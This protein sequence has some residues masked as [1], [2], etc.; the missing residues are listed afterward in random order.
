MVSAR[1]RSVKRNRMFGGALESK[2]ATTPLSR[3]AAALTIPDCSFRSA[4]PRF[5]QECGLVADGRQDSQCGAAFVSSFP[6][7]LIYVAVRRPLSPPPPHDFTSSAGRQALVMSHPSAAAA[8]A[9]PGVT[10]ALIGTALALPRLQDL[11][12]DPWVGSASD[13]LRSRWGRRRPIITIGAILA[14]LHKTSGVV[15]QWLLRIVELAVFAGAIVGARICGAAIGFIV[16]GLGLWTVLRVREPRDFAAVP[17]QR[18][19]PWATWRETL[20]QPDFH[21]IVLAQVCI[22]VSVLLVDTVGFYL[23]VFYVNGGNIKYAALLIRRSAATEQRILEARA[24]LAQPAS[25]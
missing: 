18:I 22:Y 24:T 10:P 3:P 21:R 7:V 20:R 17:R 1:C 2:R 8:P 11:I 14:G 15:N 16:A 19:R 12:V 9:A 4:L 25:P 23:N 13:N 6:K 5:V